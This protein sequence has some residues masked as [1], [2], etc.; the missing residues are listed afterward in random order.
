[1]PHGDQEALGEDG[2]GPAGAAEPLRGRAPGEHRLERRA[3]QLALT[4]TEAAAGG[5]VDLP[6]HLRGEPTHG[7]AAQPA[8]GGQAYRDTQAHQVEV[9]LEDLVAVDGGVRGAGEGGTDLG[10]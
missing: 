7:A 4:G 1:M 10:E 8:R 5:L 9:G 6:G 3:V 2:G